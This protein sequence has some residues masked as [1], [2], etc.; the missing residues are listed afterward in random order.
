[1]DEHPS[2]SHSAVSRTIKTINVLIALAGAAVLAGLYWYVWRPLPQRSGSVAAPVS[3]PATV[4][5]DTLGVPHIKASSQ[6]DAF[7]A[8]GYVTAQ[9]RLWQMDSSRRLAGGNLAE[10]IG[11]RALDLDR[12]SRQLRLRR[13][14]EDGYTRLAPEDRA[15]FA[16]YALGVNQFIAT[17]LNNPPVEFTLLG[18]QPRPWSAVDCLLVCLN[19]Y[20]SLTNTWKND[21][22]KR[23]MLAD[24]DAA[25][26]NFLFASRSGDEPLPGSN[27]WAI[28]GSRTASGK[29]ILSNDM[30]LEYSLPGVWYMTHL[31]APG[32]DVSGVSLPG[33][34]GVVVGHNQRI[35]WGITNLGFDV[36]DLYLEKL[37]DA[38]RYLFHG[39]LEQARQEHELISV[40]G[41]RPVE[42]TVWVTRHGP[43]LIADGTERISLRWTAA[44]PGFLQYPALDIDRAQNW[45]QFTAALMRW[46][47][48]GS[49]F[50][51]AD[52]DGNIG[53]HAA[54]KLPRRH[55]FAG[56]LPLD[57]SSGNF[58]WD[59]YIPFDE[60][61]SAYNPPGGIIATANQNPFPSDYP[62]PVN[63][64]FAPPD[65][66]IEIR[67][68][69]SARTGWRAQDML[70]VQTDIFCAFDKFL[71]AQVVAAYDRRGSRNPALDPSVAL[72]RAWDGR[73]DKDQAAPFLISLLYQHVRTSV[74]ESASPG[75][76][77]LYEY[78][79]GP[80]AIRKL[81]RERPGGWFRDYDAT[82]LRALVDAVDE[83]KRIQGPNAIRWKYGAYLRVEIDHP[84]LHAAME[85]IP[86]IGKFLDIFEIGPVPMS[87]SSTTIKQTT[88]LL[89][90]SM[91][92]NADLGD[93]DRS[94]LNVLIGQSGQP[95]SG[96]YKDEW[97][98]YYNGRSYPMQF[99]NVRARNR[100]ELRPG[101]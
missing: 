60:L 49:N 31:D 50:V 98:D 14:A 2:M 11:P 10:I 91:R 18:Y 39:Q 36:Q 9:D 51:Y 12:E 15:A 82:L 58:E 37:D 100:L 30:H 99:K 43:I 94:E 86:A 56:D 68:L 88:R 75:K 90:P 61:P 101:K 95:F 72:L 46:T 17:H 45:Q 13:I 89:G 79:M 73:M 27:G 53:Y 80:A 5:F 21:L 67:N 71:A 8:Q 26:V 77:Q 54:G 6:E 93:W 35:A 4:S 81:L 87:G 66:A 16:A 62:Y 29:P 48:P 1:M 20:R 19:M 83:A 92:M 3:A 42:T 24:G 69:L 52:V 38:G 78:A 64:N 55:G 65:R 40:K 59:G 63:G 25:K 97:D 41:Q 70:A 84:V 47:G 7:I 74:A 32:L 33:V 34:P 76:G 23:S 96:H 28:A 22:I 57:G 85:R 44:E